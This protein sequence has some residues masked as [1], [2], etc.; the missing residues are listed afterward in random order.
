MNLLTISGVVEMLGISR[1]TLWRLRQNGSFPSPTKLSMRSPRW[2]AEEIRQWF[3]SI[4][5]EPL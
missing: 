1:T 2:K 4:G 3:D 5:R